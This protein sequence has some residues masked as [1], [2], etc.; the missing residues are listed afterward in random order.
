MVNLFFFKGMRLIAI[1]FFFTPSL[2]CSQVIAPPYNPDANGDSFISAPDLLNFLPVFGAPF[3]PN[4][5]TID[6]IP[7]SETLNQLESTI[8]SLTTNSG[9]PIGEP[10]A[11]LGPSEHIKFHELTWEPQFNQGGGYTQLQW[12]TD[13]FL[14]I[15]DAP[16]LRLIVVPD[17]VDES[18]FANDNL[19]ETN[20]FDDYLEGD[21]GIVTF[22]L[23]AD[24]MLVLYSPGLNVVEGD[25]F[26]DKGMHWT[27]LLSQATPSIES[28]QAQVDSLAL[29]VD[30]ISSAAPGCQGLSHWDYH[31]YSYE[32][33]EVGDQCWFKEN[34][35]TSQ[36]SNGDVISN[37]WSIT[38]FT[39][40]WAMEACDIELGWFYNGPARTDP[41]NICPSSWHV[42]TALDWSRLA[43]NTFGSSL[44][45]NSISG[46][47]FDTVQLFYDYDTGQ[48]DCVEE[49]YNSYGIYGARYNVPEP[50]VTAF[51]TTVALTP[52]GPFFSFENNTTG[53]G[54]L[55]R[56]I[57][58]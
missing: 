1:L 24:M 8:D 9:I 19:A 54:T 23:S 22:P 15:K 26:G 56:C 32:L 36:F 39:E 4:E 10:A 29:V 16:G 46:I 6:G 33:V 38:N 52:F 11:Y 18:F 20:F 50:G 2:I 28:L 35:R 14:R 49:E 21:F 37:E 40:P 58:D 31:D 48:P 27:P 57:K 42:P 3:T 51:Y 41:R 47:D 5:T 30:A 43:S 55:V 12:E 34:L 25:E 13:G 53:A 44:I 45:T 7:L 17:S